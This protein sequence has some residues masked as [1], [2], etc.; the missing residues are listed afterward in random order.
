MDKLEEKDFIFYRSPKDGQTKIRVALTD[1]TIWS[2]V[3]GMAIL[4]NTSRQ[5]IEKHIKKIFSSGELSKDSVCNHRL[6]TAEDGKE[7][8][9]NTYNL[10]LIIALGYRVDSYEATQFRIWATKILKKYVQKGFVLDDERLKQGSNFFGEDYFSELLD[11]IRE[12]RASERRFYQKITDLYRDASYDYDKDSPLTSMFYKIVQNK[13]IYAVAGMT[14]AEIIKSRADA[15]EPNMGLTNWKAQA[16]GG[17]VI[18]RDIIVSKN[19]L[20][21]NEINSLNRIVSMFLDYAENL[22]ERKVTMSMQDWNTALD[23]FLQFN[24]YDVLKDA[25]SIKKKVADS[26]AKKEFSKFRVTQDQNFQSDFDKITLEIKSGNVP[27]EKFSDYEEVKAELSDFDKK[28]KQAIG[29]NPNKD[30][31]NGNKK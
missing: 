29:Y 28:L 2:T 20:K 13:L 18:V 11:R 14:A 22:V 30:K 3:K 10:D 17:K 15:N 25:G 8:G 21:E 19:Y 12:I 6:H 7:Y 1:G 4:F 31:K 5:N 16:I 23:D 9:V 24:R 27:N 26:I